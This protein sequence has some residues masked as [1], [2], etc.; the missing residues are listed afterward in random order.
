VVESPFNLDEQSAAVLTTHLPLPIP[1]G[2]REF[3]E[4]LAA[5]QVGFLSLTGGKTLTLFA[6]RTRMEKVAHLVR[7]RER[8]LGERGVELL[9]QGEESTTQLTDRFRADDGAVLYGLRTFWE[10]FDAPGDHAVLPRRREATMA[11]SR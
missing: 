10:G 2:E 8:E 3:C 7:Q 1:G 11:T 9:V 5:D 4:E 6:A